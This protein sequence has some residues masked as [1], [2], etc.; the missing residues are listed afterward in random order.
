MCGSTERDESNRRPRDATGPRRIGGKIGAL[1]C[2]G[3]REF[4]CKA[5]SKGCRNMKRTHTNW[6]VILQ[7]SHPEISARVP[8]VALK[9]SSLRWVI[10]CR[11]IKPDG[12]RLN[13]ASPHLRWGTGPA[14]LTSAK[15]AMFLVLLVLLSPCLSAVLN[16]L[17]VGQEKNPSIC[18]L[19]ILLFRVTGMQGRHIE[20]WNHSN[21][22]VKQSNE[23]T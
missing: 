4:I 3:E 17:H 6:M 16:W 13:Q 9:G 7:I 18:F 19:L 15:E 10:R 22:W 8:S 11:V 2:D 20:T 1:V 21:L 23:V 5:V 12:E 14:G